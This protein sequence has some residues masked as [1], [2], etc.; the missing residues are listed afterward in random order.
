MNDDMFN[1]HNRKVLISKARSLRDIASLSLQLKSTVRLA[2]R[3]RERERVRET[4]KDGRFQSGDDLKTS[5]MEDRQLRTLL[6]QKVRTFQARNLELVTHAL[7]QNFW[8]YLCVC[9]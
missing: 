1:E 2:E 4:C 6:F 7:S 5:A 9:R 3:E 8:M